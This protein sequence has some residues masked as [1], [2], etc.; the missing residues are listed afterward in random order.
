MINLDLS[1]F[2]EKYQTVI[3]APEVTDASLKVLGDFK[4][5]LNFKVLDFFP[6][7]VID[8]HDHIALIVLAI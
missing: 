4:V 5:K 6:I 7:S 8:L 3:I 1:I 2:S